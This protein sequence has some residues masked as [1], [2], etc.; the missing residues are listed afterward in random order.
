MR[1]FKDMV[2][3]R[4][5]TVNE[6]FLKEFKLF[7]SKKTIHCTSEHDK[8]LTQLFEAYRHDPVP[9]GNDLADLLVKHFS[10]PSKT[11]RQVIARLIILGLITSAKQLKEI[12]VRPPE[13][14]S[15]RNRCLLNNGESSEWT[16]QEIARLRDIVE[17][18]KGSKNMLTEI[19]NERKVDHD[20]AV[21]RCLEQELIMDENRSDKYIPP[22]RARLDNENQLKTAVYKRKRTKVQNVDM[23]VSKELKKSKSCKKKFSST[24]DDERSMNSS[25]EEEEKEANTSHNS[26]SKHNTDENTSPEYINQLVE[27]NRPS[28][29]VDHITYVNHTQ[30][31][32]T[33]GAVS[34]NSESG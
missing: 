14:L 17:L 21:Q 10:D 1:Q 13:P 19:M 26:D 5:T 2:L 18:H 34:P 30:D 4:A 12:I 20:L 15:G 31:D 33:C 25:Y 29:Q 11:R 6:S 22:I 9:S 3:L 28:D 7:Y 16:E 27:S 32:Y 23:D 8:E 24:S